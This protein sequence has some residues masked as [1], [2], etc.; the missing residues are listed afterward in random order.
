[1]KL[2]RF[3][4]TRSLDKLLFEQY[5]MEFLSQQGMQSYELEVLCRDVHNEFFWGTVFSSFPDLCRELSL[6][7]S[8]MSIFSTHW[9]FRFRWKRKISFRSF[10][11]CFPIYAFWHSKSSK[12]CLKFSPK[13]HRQGNRESVHSEREWGW[14]PGEGEDGLCG[15]LR[16]IT[17]E[18]TEVEGRSRQGQRKCML[19]IWLRRSLG[20]CCRRAHAG[21][22]GEE[23]IWVYS[24]SWRD[25]WARF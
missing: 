5:I 4:Y 16:D 1:M 15:Q 6:L 25:P 22:L 8:F 9:S 14:T 7:F 11:S 23:F 10:V 13:K 17:M 2:G 21:P 19:G 12:E 18:K 24:T 20:C 3:P